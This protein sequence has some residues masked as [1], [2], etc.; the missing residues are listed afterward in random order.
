MKTELLKSAHDVV[1]HA[2]GDRDAQL[3]YL[4]EAMIDRI[5]QLETRL[6]RLSDL[7]VGEERGSFTDQVMHV[8]ETCSGSVRVALDLTT[9]D[10]DGLVLTAIEENSYTVFTHIE[11]EIDEKLE[12]LTDSHQ[13]AVAVEE[14]TQ[15]AI[16][17]TVEEVIEDRIACDFLDGND[18]EDVVRK[19]L[20]SIL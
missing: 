14:A 11:A 3:V 16:V 9:A 8:M 10:I 18:A 2:R 1:R 17:K 5:Q 12:S 15:S 7:T 13:F 4:L 19:G 20:R 6:D